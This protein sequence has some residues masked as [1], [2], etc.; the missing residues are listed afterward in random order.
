M[1]LGLR[2]AGGQVIAP[3]VADGHLVPAPAELAGDVAKGHRH[4]VDFGR[5][6]FGDDRELH[7]G[8]GG[9]ILV[10]GT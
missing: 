8:E 10:P 4:A 2:R 5:E 1:E 6:G 7:M 3:R 9:R